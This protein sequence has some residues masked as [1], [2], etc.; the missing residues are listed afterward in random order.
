MAVDRITA[1][2][3]GGLLQMDLQEKD[4]NMIRYKASLVAQGF[5]QKF[6]TDCDEVFAPV[7]R[8]VSFRFLLLTVASQRETVVKYT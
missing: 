7:V 8:Q 3:Q 2:T 4:G 5:T 6:E 1:G